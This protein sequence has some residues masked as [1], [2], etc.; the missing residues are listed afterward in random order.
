LFFAGRGFFLKLTL[1]RLSLVIFCTQLLSS[2]ATQSVYAFRSEPGDDVSP[3]DIGDGPTMFNP[4]THGGVLPRLAGKISTVSLQGA[5]NSVTW[6]A[7]TT[8]K[9]PS[10]LWGAPVVRLPEG[11][12]FKE[13]DQ[14]L[15]RFV[16]NN[17]S[18][19]QVH[20]ADLRLDRNRTHYSG[21]FK[22]ITYARIFKLEGQP[23]FVENAYITFRFKY[24]SLI[25]ITN[26]TYGDIGIVEAPVTSADEAIQSVMEDSKFNDEQDK[27]SA[28]RAELQPFYDQNGKIHFRFVYQL[29]VRKT[30]PK[31]AYD[32]S[33][34]ALD[35]RIIRILNQF[36]TAQVLGEYYPRLPGQIKVGPLSEVMVGSGSDRSPTDE[37]GNFEADA[38]ATAELAGRHVA[39]TVNK[40]SKVVEQEGGDGNIVFKASNR[41]S[42]TMAYVHV[43]RVNAFVRNFIKIASI[44]PNNPQNNFLDKPVRVNTRVQSAMMKNCNAWFDPSEL[45]LNFLEA[46]EKCE[47][48]SHFGDIMYHEWGHALDN[49]LGGI[50]DSSFSEA[51]GDITAMLMTGDSKLAPG[52]VKGSSAPIRDLTTFKHYPE[53]QNADPHKESLILSGAWY[54]TFMRMRE[55]YGDEAGKMKTAEIFFKHLVSTESYLESYQGALVADDDDNNLENGTPHMCYFNVAFAKRGI[56]AADPRCNPNSDKHME[57]L[58]ESTLPLE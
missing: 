35:G 51:V 50:H 5:E 2:L 25:Q 23:F 36:H 28:A 22:Y 18:V 16:E 20:A 27:I 26:F 37:N 42:E 9:G 29:N 11:I 10:Q 14:L 45:S 17:S 53:D 6:S 57:G 8:T 13:I 38:G 15:M 19:F 46:D 7:T 32:Y 34:S 39:L 47:A 3:Y 54:E 30:F 52:F 40:K 58:A 24:N 1:A 12:S 4:R 56:A 49:A 43:Q 48:S 21:P 31:G 55:H 33:V 44:D 41:L